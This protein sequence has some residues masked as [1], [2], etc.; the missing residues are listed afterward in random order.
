MPFHVPTVIVP[1]ETD[2]PFTAEALR[3]PPEIVPPDSV[4]PLMVE[5]QAKAPLELVTV[6]PVEPEPPPRRMSPVLVPPIWTWPVVPALTVRL[7]A[8]VDALIAGLAPENVRVVALKVLVLMVLDVDIVVMPERA[9][10]VET[11]R[12]LLVRE[13]V[14]VA[15]PIAVLD[16]P[17]VLREIVPPEIVAPRL[18]VRS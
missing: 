8:A 17:V 7:V 6:Q 14:P 5:V 2:R 16:V 12:P 15:L 11:L 13:N 18:P 10:A 3:L 9:P 4:A 1:P